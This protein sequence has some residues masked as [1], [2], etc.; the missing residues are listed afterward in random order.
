MRIATPTFS[1]FLSSAFEDSEGRARRSAARGLPRLRNLCEEN[2][3]FPGH[4]PALGRAP[5]QQIMA[6]SLLA[7]E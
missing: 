5:N 7:I 3:A 1:A 6:I 2:N 4:R